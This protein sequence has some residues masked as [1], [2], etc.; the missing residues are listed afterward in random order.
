MNISGAPMYSRE[1]QA[2]RN[3]GEYRETL[4]KLLFLY[5]MGIEKVI[6][7]VPYNTSVKGDANNYADL[8]RA[9]FSI[10]ILKEIFTS[11]ALNLIKTASTFQ[12][13]SIGPSSSK[14]M[15]GSILRGETTNKYDSTVY[16]SVNYNYSSNNIDQNKLQSKVDEKVKEIKNLIKTNQRLKKLNPFIEVITLQNLMDVPVI[17][18]TWPYQLDTSALFSLLSAAISTRTRLDKWESVKSL[19]TKLKTMPDNSIYQ[20]FQ[21]L[22]NVEKNNATPESIISTSLPGGKPDEF[23]ILKQQ[24]WNEEDEKKKNKL[25]LQYDALTNDY[26]QKYI[27]DLKQNKLRELEIAFMYMLDPDKLAAR[28]GFSKDVGQASAVMNKVSPQTDL[29]FNRVREQ[30]I[31]FV[32]GADSLFSSAYMLFSP[33]APIN[34]VWAE[35]TMNYISMR[36]R[37]IDTINSD[38]DIFF[39][40]LKTAFDK[41]MES[42]LDEASISVKKMMRSCEVAKEEFITSTN[43]FH[44]IMSSSQVPPTFSLEMVEKFAKAIDKLTIKYESLNK[45]VLYSLE[46]FFGKEYLDLV[47][48]SVKNLVDA[49]CDNFFKPFN[50]TKTPDTNL[51]ARL[52]AVNTEMPGAI[53]E[54]VHQQLLLRL[55]LSTKLIL[56]TIFLYI[57]KI[58]LCD[59]VEVADVEFDIAKGDVL[60][61]VNYC[62]VLPI[63]IINALFILYTKRN[64]KN[65]VI[66]SGAGFNPLNNSNTKSVVK[67]LSMQLGI[68]NL[69]VIDQKKKEILYS[70]KYLQNNVEKLKIPA[71]E[72][73]VKYHLQNNETGISQVYY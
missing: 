49:A 61:P 10:S 19:I 68:P 42:T 48:S 17:V 1:V 57:F 32:S 56:E 39:K 21:V 18:G 8:A 50:L 46:Q 51:Q 2:M 63:E 23:T 4:Q 20:I 38:Y 36:S 44:Q 71:V 11:N 70:F 55:T 58:N 53:N 45:N 30:I 35:E 24:I 34:G 62:I 43:L 72:T 33:A 3:P 14:N 7:S 28:N 27:G 16:N 22:S 60:D 65:A 25:I 64:W 73:F 37:F 66:S 26:A 54:R 31:D 5:P 59:F 9:F 13:Q 41:R 6:G 69:I 12:S 47:N 52:Y 15:I 67:V 29:M 40:K